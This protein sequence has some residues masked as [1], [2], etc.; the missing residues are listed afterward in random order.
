[1]ARTGPARK[2]QRVIRYLTGIGVAGLREQFYDIV[3]VGGIRIKVSNRVVAPFKSWE[4][5]TMA[6]ANTTPKGWKRAIIHVRPSYD[7]ES[8]LVTMP[9]EDWAPMF[10]AWVEANKERCYGSE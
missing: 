2:T 8:S 5:I 6:M 10:H 3:G 1:M 4:D 9:L 7:V